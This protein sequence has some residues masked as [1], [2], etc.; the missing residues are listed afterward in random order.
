LLNP[1]NGDWLDTKITKLGTELLDIKGRK[2]ETTHYRLN[3]S[4]EG[5]PKLNIELWYETANNNWVALK[6][7]TPE[8]Y[9]INYKL[10]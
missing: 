3:A 8:D 6:S 5:K 4:L 7:I 10:K 2:V 9:I 1:Q